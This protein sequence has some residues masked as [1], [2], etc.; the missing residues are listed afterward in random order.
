MKVTI[1]SCTGGGPMERLARALTALGVEAQVLEEFSDRRWRELMASRG[2]GRARARIGSMLVFPFRAIA[3]GFFR[4]PGVLVATTNPFYLPLVLDR[5]A[6]PASG[7]GGGAGLRC[8]PRRT[9]GFRRS[10]SC[11]PPRTD[12][13]ARESLLAFACRRGGLHRPGDGGARSRAL[14]LPALL[15]GDRDRGQRLGVRRGVRPC[16][17]CRERARALVPRQGRGELRRQHGADA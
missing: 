10:G 5:H 6:A 13:G 17:R 12:R 4:R 9:G 8:L 11:R 3:H 15:G 7:T 14:R 16:R 1:A 2:F